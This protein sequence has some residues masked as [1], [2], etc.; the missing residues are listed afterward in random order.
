MWGFQLASSTKRNLKR[1]RSVFAA[2]EIH[3]IKEFSE[4]LYSALEEHFAFIFGAFYETAGK[5]KL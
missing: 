5:N 2:A 3:A 1:N 4:T